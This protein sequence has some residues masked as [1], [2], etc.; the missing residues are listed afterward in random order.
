[1]LAN[2][3]LGDRKRSLFIAEEARRLVARWNRIY[4]LSK[5]Q[6]LRSFWL[7]S[8]DD[9]D[10]F[11]DHG[12]RGRIYYAWAKGEGC[13]HYGNLVRWFTGKL[14]PCLPVRD[15]YARRLSFF[16]TKPTVMQNK[17]RHMSFCSH[18]PLISSKKTDAR[19]P[20]H[21]KDERV[22]IRGCNW[23]ALGMT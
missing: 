17:E 23:G 16:D 13:G 22:H 10:S 14:A 19:P 12:E 21:F 5:L 18:P 2:V 8:F 4:T 20:L 6:I 1:M 9:R 7:P 11:A 15:I 3:F